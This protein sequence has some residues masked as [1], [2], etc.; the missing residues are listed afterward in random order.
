MKHRF[1]EM[2]CYVVCENEQLVVD[3][4]AEVGVPVRGDP[5]GGGGVAGD[6]DCDTREQEGWGKA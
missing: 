2:I 6:E 3:R 5:G 4:I 1:A